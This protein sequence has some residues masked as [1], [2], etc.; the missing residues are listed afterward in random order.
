MRIIASLALAAALLGCADQ[1]AA[2]RAFLASLIGRPETGVVQ[3]LGRPARV[4]AVGSTRY[5]AYD[6]GRPAP[7]GGAYGGC[8]MTLMVARGQ[9]QS[10]TL[11]GPACDAGHGEGWLA[12]G[13]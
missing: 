7:G 4:Y 9:V 6:E 2:R 8:Q 5:L 1:E 10:W 13:T 3:A 11:N 12:F